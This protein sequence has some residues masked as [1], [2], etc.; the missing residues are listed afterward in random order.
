LVNTTTKTRKRLTRAESLAQARAQLQ[1]EKVSPKPKRVEDEDSPGPRDREQWLVLPRHLARYVGEQAVVSQGYIWTHRVDR[2]S[3]RTDANRVKHSPVRA[4]CLGPVDALNPNYQ[5]ENNGSGQQ[6]TKGAKTP[7][8]VLGS[9]ASRSDD[10]L[11]ETEGVLS[12]AGGRPKKNGCDDL[13]LLLAAE[14][15][16]S[17]AIAK[18]LRRD[19]VSI[20]SRTV[21]RRLA[22]IRGS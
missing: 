4:V 15:L 10:H 7:S 6:T 19:G 22:E 1:A 13:I 8:S 20:S 2:R 11:L 5:R 16:G 9:K 18:V 3:A 17:K 21:S 12:P 14:G